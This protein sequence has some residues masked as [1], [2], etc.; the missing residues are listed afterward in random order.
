MSYFSNIMKQVS[1]KEF[2]YFLLKL[3]VPVLLIYYLSVKF[4]TI[5]SSIFKVNSIAFLAAGI[6]LTFLNIYIQFLK[7]ELLCNDYFGI[8]SRV[9]VIKSLLSGIAAGIFTPGRLGE[10][11]GRSIILKKEKLG[12]VMLTTIYEKL[13][14]QFWILYVG[15][16]LVEIYASEIYE[17]PKYFSIPLIIFTV[18]IIFIIMKY[19]KRFSLTDN[20]I[21]KATKKLPFLKKLLFNLYNTRR[22]N[23]TLKR[24]LFGLSLILYIV[25]IVQYAFF[26]SSYLNG[27]EIINYLWVGGLVIFITT[28]IPSI[29]IGDLGIREGASVLILSSFGFS[30]QTGFN[31]SLL[32]FCFNIFIPSV[33]GLY[34]L[35][36]SK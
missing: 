36:R 20:Q 24:Q 6:A 23:P 17:I 16:V 4:I 35:V 7:W 5:D 2:L 3:F 25:I 13:L 27:A 32:L 12:E 11:L 1:S 21:E 26:V 9:E 31:A 33:I 10:F 29:S 14:N 30:Q 34:F 18:A 19:L 28:L 15:I 8:I 22:I